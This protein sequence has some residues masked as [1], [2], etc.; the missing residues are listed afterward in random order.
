MAYASVGT[1]GNNQ[2]K[3]SGTTVVITTS[4]TAE[5]G[6]LVVVITAWDNTD[7]TD[8]DTT[9]LS[10]TDS[11]GGNTWTLVREYTDTEAGAAED[12]VTGAIFISRLTNQIASG[13]TITVTS[14]TAR[15]AK[16]VSAWEFTTAAAPVIEQTNFAKATGTDPASMS[17]TSLPA[18]DYLFIH[19]H[20]A[21]QPNG[22]TYTKDANYTAL[23]KIGTTGGA[24]GTN[25][26]V[27]GGFRIQSTSGTQTVD[28]ATGTDANQHVQLLAAIYES[29]ATTHNG[30]TASTWTFGSTTAGFATL[31]GAASASTYTF[32]STTVGGAR[33]RAANFEPRLERRHDCHQ[34]R[35]CPSRL[36]RRD[37]RR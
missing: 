18:R 10:V 21:E 6:N 30:A 20:A 37:H 15:V 3:A 32:S 19:C 9:R 28:A 17:L 1:L 11:A 4:A 31:L 24:S 27:A 5:A 23:T 7:T 34:R 13:G 8:G 2:S 29:T 33:P 35:W 25:T 26:F 12:G 14:D 36:G 16:S 22:V